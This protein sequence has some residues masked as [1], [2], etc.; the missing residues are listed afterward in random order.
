M[1]CLRSGA[2]G[3]P[4]FFFALE[5]LFSYLPYAA[6]I[7]LRIPSMAAFCVALVCIFVFVRR[8][9]DELTAL[10][11][12]A[13]L[14]LS[15]MLWVY[16]IEAR[17]YAL[18]TAATAAALM[19]YQR[20]GSRLWAALFG[21]SLTF[22]VAIHYYA[23][24]V[25]A[26]FVLAEFVFVIKERSIRAAVW[27]AFAVSAVPLLISWRL[28]EAVKKL[29]GAHFWGVPTFHNLFAT[30]AISYDT[31]RLGPVLCIT[32]IGLSVGALFL[33]DSGSD[34]EGNSTPICCERTAVLAIAALPVIECAAAKIT[35]GGY[36]ARYALPLTLAVPATCG[37]YL[38]YFRAKNLNRVLIAVPLIAI[39]ALGVLREGYFWRDR[40]IHHTKPTFS[41]E[42]V[43]EFVESHAK[44]GLP[45]AVSS[46][47]EYFQ[48]FY[49]ASPAWRDRFVY[50][51]DSDAAIQFSNL[52]SDT[53]ERNLTQNEQCA[54]SI[55]AVKF[56][57]FAKENST[58][59]VYAESPNKS[60]QWWPRALAEKGFNLK[61]LADNKSQE[62]YL[63]TGK[64]VAQ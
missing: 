34:T 21:L 40:I 55:R 11:C 20:A 41:A 23:V 57:D 64:S 24:F 15:A 53:A 5:K 59:L 61:V 43:E 32:L 29:Y 39:V 28:I 47:L 44:S 3:Q 6:E 46:P 10:V 26:A 50:L 19:C 16:A 1:G 56:G 4:P 45:I 31:T 30:Y 9:N 13:T 7:S 38:A 37:Y 62:L 51:V 17:P 8:R 35:S 36:A 52:H 33:P 18:M 42:R 25:V 63:V 48:L 58:F 27:I 54:S 22:G 49:Y 12:A 60:N 2:D 14:F